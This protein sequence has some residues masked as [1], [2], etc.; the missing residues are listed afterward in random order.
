MNKPSAK[1]I[2]LY[3]QAR[4]LRLVLDEIDGDLCDLERKGDGLTTEAEAIKTVKLKRLAPLIR[5]IK[6]ALHE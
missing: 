2:R 3:T 5:R 4:A 6:D 1:W